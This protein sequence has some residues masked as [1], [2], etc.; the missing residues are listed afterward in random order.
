[1]TE[2]RHH[3]I[4]LVEDEPTDVLLM[5]EA[6][7]N[8]SDNNDDL[9]TVG[10]LAD[11][12]Q[13]LS[14]HPFDIVLLDLGLPDSQGL[15]TFERLHRFAPSLPKLV[16]TGLSDE[17]VGVR[18]M[19]LGAQ[20][21]LVKNQIHPTMLGRTV[22]FA[23]ER[24]RAALELQRSREQLRLLTARLLETREEERT[25]IS[26]EIHDELGQQLTGL[27]MDFRWL[28]RKLLPLLA[29]ADF[30]ALGQKFGEM[31][32]VT[33]STIET[34]KRIAIELRPGVL[35]NLGLAEAIRDESRRFGARTNLSIQNTI[36]NDLPK[37]SPATATALFRIFQELLINIYRHAAARVVK[38]QLGVEEEMLLLSVSDDGKG[39]ATELLS[40]PTSLGILGMQERAAMVGA[41]F[42]IESTLGEGTYAEVQVPIEP[43]S[44]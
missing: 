37:L 8:G 5:R 44:P 6:L 36:A 1:M 41:T 10:Y 2:S 11:A 15:N 13:K 3:R 20:D 26:R 35:D 25:R 32:T 42:H 19:Q 28:E 30:V 40:H 43:T 33:D 21:Y 4:L 24:H 22:R 14:E 39:F 16:L 17:S 18:A 38:V 7:S 31:R 27:K 34:V 29:P 9:V 23:I 12:E